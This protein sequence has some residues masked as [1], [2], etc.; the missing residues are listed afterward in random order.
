MCSSVT[1]KALQSGWDVFSQMA[2]FFSAATDVCPVIGAELMCKALA[3]ADSRVSSLES[4]PTPAEGDGSEVRGQDWSMV[5]VQVHDGDLL[6][7]PLGRSIVR[8]SSSVTSEDRRPFN[9]LS[10]NSC[11]QTHNRQS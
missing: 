7:S 2:G 9:L 11:G 10:Q 4:G 5:H 1:V 6:C 8:R 3:M